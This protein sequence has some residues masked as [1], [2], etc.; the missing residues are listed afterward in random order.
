M[1][2][3]S[4]GSMPT[5]TIL[6]PAGIP[7]LAVKPARRRPARKASPTKTLHLVSRIS[8][9]DWSVGEAWPTTSRSG[10]LW[11][12]RTKAS[13]KR[14]FSINKKARI[15]ELGTQSTIEDQTSDQNTL[16]KN[17][18]LAAEV[19]PGRQCRQRV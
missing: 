14:R 1:K 3:S 5:R 4:P 19:K 10:R 15:D 2:C 16:S 6:L 7:P 9:G 12:R 8:R 11:N 18:E 13:R 17:K